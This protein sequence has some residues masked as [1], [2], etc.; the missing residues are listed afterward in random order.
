MKVQVLFLLVLVAAVAY[1]TAR[2][3]EKYTGK[4]DNVNVDEILKNERLLLNYYKCL[5]DEGKC[6][7]D[8]AELR[9]VM[10][11]ALETDCAKCSEKQKEMAKKV[12][13]FMV[14]NKPDLWTKLAD[15]YDPEKKY[16]TKYEEEA[17]KN[18]LQL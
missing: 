8:G 9:K 4:F 7:A 10:P 12:I 18:G 5:M 14:N 15:K 6:T 17:K 13:K 11:D 1:V 3:D 2:P 16:R